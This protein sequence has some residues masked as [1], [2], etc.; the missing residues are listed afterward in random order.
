LPGRNGVGLAAIALACALL[1]PP[2]ARAAEAAAPAASAYAGYEPADELE[3]LEYLARSQPN[4]A[5]TELQHFADTLKPDDPR[6]L[7]ALMEA[8][9]CDVTLAMDE[10]VEQVA[11]R[12]EALAGD[13]QLAR[14]AA[15]LLRG[16]WLDAHGDVGRA[17]RQVIEATALFPRD[18]PTW[19][20][21][22]LL[23]TAGDIKQRGGHY[24]EAMARFNEALRLADETA[25]LWRRIDMRRA[26]AG[27]LFEAGQ[28]DKALEMSGELMDLSGK[29]GDEIGLSKAYT[30]R[31]ILG[32]DRS[33]P[34]E[35]IADWRAALEHARMSGNPQQ[36][37][38]SLANIADYYL[39]QG[40]FS[41]A[42]DMSQRALA[43]ARDIKNQPAESVAL[44]NA[45]LALIGMKRKDEGISLVHQSLALE[46]HAGSARYIADT[47][48]QLGDAL[49]KAGY[50]DDSLAAFRQY[51]Q[52]AD[53]LNQQDRQ[54]AVIEL[55][56][57]FGNERRQHELDML[58]REGRLKDEELLHRSLEMRLW[59]VAGVSTLLLLAVV[60]SLARRLRVRNRQ[61]SDSN[62]RLRIQAE[63]DPLTG[64]ANRHHLHEVMSARPGQ[65]LEGTLYLIDL[66]NF[67]EINDR[68]GHAGGDSVLVE[69]THRLR[70]ALREGDLVVRWGGE[71]FLV[72]V[73]ALPTSEAEML[74]QRLLAAFADTPVM[75]EGRPLRV[76]ASIGYASFPMRTDASTAPASDTEPGLEVGWERAISLADSA[77][78]L[79]KARGRNGA[80]CIRRVGPAD[81]AA[82]EAVGDNLEA[83]WQDGRVDLHFQQGPGPRGDTP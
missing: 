29:A 74:A 24:D 39:S 43:L 81:A 55:Q 82:L 16:Q 20:H 48:N 18:L 26:V 21:L 62:E 77:M 44:A 17:E 45:G 58:G 32:R 83:A 35:I 10:Q 13:N 19:L 41:T 3:R 31:A 14:P 65:G 5:V 51:R 69:I 1:A 42:Y 78:Y 27:A 15:M 49:E 2:Q 80:C 66:D 36:L 61:L 67:K 4:R 76:S 72:L 63:I 40:D 9:A 70:A 33:P 37:S 8:G 79:A 7:E 75:H 23:A 22:R 56:E 12:I 52:I 71:E 47:A 38:L 30:L 64:V 34:A 25:P 11:R 46:E 28:H 60:G 53:E 68:C 59:T 54:R 57:G 6:L 73:R 50:L